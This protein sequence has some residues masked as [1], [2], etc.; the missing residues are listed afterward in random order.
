[1]MEK[2]RIGTDISL[3]VDIRQYLTKHNLKEACVYWPDEP[4]FYTI[5]SNPFVNKKF[6]VYYP[7]QFTHADG[8]P[9]RF[10][11]EG[12]PVSI[13]SIEAILINTTREEKI[14]ELRHK[15]EHRQKEEAIRF[16]KE[17]WKFHKEW[18]DKMRAYRND[19]RRHSRFIARFPI[20][21][22]MECFE[23]TPFDIC[24]SGYPTYRAYPRHY[25][26]APYHGF[27]ICPKWHDIYRPVCPVPP[28][29]MMDPYMVPKP[30]EEVKIEDDSR[31]TAQVYATDKQSIVEVLF[32]A[33]D[34]LYAGVYSMLLKV[35]VYVPGFKEQNTKTITI[36][37]PD[38]FEIVNNTSQLGDNQTVKVTV[39]PIEYH[40][41]MGEESTTRPN[42]DIYT[43]GGHVDGNTLS[44]ERTDGA[45]VDVNLSSIVG[46]YDDN[47]RS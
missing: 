17:K 44:L 3:S 10:R 4:N 14:K 42:I 16:E 20:E 21:P 12:S 47:N 1:M 9:V 36:D 37:I 29:P 40:L 33:S 11:P 15:E 41:S 46:W 18:E 32:P 23:P 39:K 19:L 8:E 28:P 35:E 5:D 38:V 7:N 26:F 24:C 13:R 34:Q 43:N 6:E 45:N 2:F 31:Y 27:G 22:A 30:A 25:L